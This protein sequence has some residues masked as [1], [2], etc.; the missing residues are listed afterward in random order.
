MAQNE[1]TTVAPASDKMFIALS[2]AFAIGGAVAYQV[3]SGQDFFLRL[4]VVLGG[5]ALAVVFFFISHTGKRF[6]GFARSSVDEAKRVVWP[7]RKEAVQMTAIVF[8]FVLIMSIY[9]LV[10]DK[11]LAWSLYDLILGWG[12]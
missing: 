1:I 10:V 8:G 12:S 5:V 3:L 4:A 6:V 9:L 2:I 7:Q 11:L